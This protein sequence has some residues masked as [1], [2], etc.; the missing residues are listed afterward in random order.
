M[1]NTAIRNM[2]DVLYRESHV[3]FGPGIQPADIYGLDVQ[4]DIGLDP[5]GN[6]EGLVLGPVVVFDGV[7]SELVR[8][9]Q[10]S[11]L[12]GDRKLVGTGD[13]FV[14]DFYRKGCR[15]FTACG[16]VSQDLGV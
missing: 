2:T 5:D 1:W 14:R 9:T 4:P 6:L 8:V 15:C 13:C 10:V 16:K 3:P 7:S 11:I 12:E